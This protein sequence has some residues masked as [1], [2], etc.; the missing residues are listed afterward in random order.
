MT[1]LF[2]YQHFIKGGVE[3]LI[4][5]LTSYYEANGNNIIICCEDMIDEYKLL[6]SKTNV[7]IISRNIINYE[8]LK[9]INIVLTMNFED[10]FF[11]YCY[12]N[13]YNMKY[14]NLL[15]VVAPRT[16]SHS[17][18]YTHKKA[19]YIGCV[20]YKKFVKRLFMN[21]NIIFM[22]EMCYRDSNNSLNFCEENSSLDFI[23]IP[24]DFPQFDIK[25]IDEKVFSRN[26]TFNIL[27]VSRADYPYKG[28]HKGLIDIFKLISKKYSNVRLKIIASYDS[29]KSQKNIYMLK[30]WINE[31]G[32]RNIELIEGLCYKELLTEY[33]KSHLYI[34]MGTTLIEAAA[35][36]NIV[37]AV[38]PYKYQCISVDYFHNKVDWLGADWNMGKTSFNL[39]DHA[40]A[41][42]SK[43]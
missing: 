41:L 28:Y 37:I 30:K 18:F 34:G 35:N 26:K 29:E 10:F 33:E 13:K 7:N 15:Y 14:K 4:L 9:N 5:R 21:K 8:L 32:C 17:P 1:I 12:A 27:T 16:L 22:D 23:P 6:F 43:R 20:I 3:T 39:I 31:S 2:D 38:E 25:K 40:I 19:N 11:Y 24:F 42:N 36:Y